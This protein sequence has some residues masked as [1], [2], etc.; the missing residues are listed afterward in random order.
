MTQVT[1]AAAI[2]PLTRGQVLR[3][4]YIALG[5]LVDA[6]GILYGYIHRLQP[7]GST[8]EFDASQMTS[9]RGGPHRGRHR[10]GGHFR[11]RF[12]SGREDEQHRSV[13][14]RLPPVDSVD[15]HHDYVGRRRRR[16]R[17]LCTTTTWQN[18]SEINNAMK[19]H[20]NHQSS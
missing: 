8:D 4:I 20:H 12:F 14:I 1:A 7:S 2:L 15:V 9:P 18:C 11:R 19:I 3:P 5:L 17:R 10:A 6:R 13:F 16:R